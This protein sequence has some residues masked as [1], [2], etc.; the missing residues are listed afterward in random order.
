MN[1][2][3]EKCSGNMR[4]LND[5]L[6]VIGGKWRIP[7]LGSILAGNHRFREIERSIPKLSTKVLSTELKILE[8][9]YLL[10]RTVIEDTSVTILYKPTEHAITLGK[11]LDE[12]IKWGQAHGQKIREV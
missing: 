4:A 9:N 1:D 5:A 11:V 6:Y 7:I 12:L 10:T 8:Q 3:Y 2:E